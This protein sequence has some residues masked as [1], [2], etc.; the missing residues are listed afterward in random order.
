MT[1]EGP[2]GSSLEDVAKTCETNWSTE[3]TS[4]TGQNHSEYGHSHSVNADDPSRSTFVPK[5]PTFSDRLGQETAS[6]ISGPSSTGPENNNQQYEGT[7]TERGELEKVLRRALEGS[8]KKRFISNDNFDRIITQNSI[9]KELIRLRVGQKSHRQGLS[10]VITLSRR[11][12]FA[13]LCLVEKV[14]TVHD[15]I[16]EGL[17]DNDLPFVFHSEAE[18]RSREGKIIELFQNGQWKPSEKDNFETYQWYM[19]MPYLRLNCE[20]DPSVSQYIFEE[21]LVLPFAVLETYKEGGF[22][23]VRKVTFHS[24]HFNSEDFNGGGKCFFAIKSLYLPYDPH[25]RHDPPNQEV[26]ALIRMNETKHPHLVRLLATY[27]YEGGLNLIFPWADGNLQNFWKK[28]SWNNHKTPRDRTL[29]EW[30]AEQCLG[31]A[32]GLK[33][34]HDSS[35]E[36]SETRAQA[37]NNKSA[38]KNYG[39]HGDLKPENILWFRERGSRSGSNEFGILRI[40]D[41]GLA[42]FHGT[43]SK[44]SVPSENLG[45]TPTYRAPEFDIK[46]KVAPSYDIWC[47]GCVLLEFVE[48]YLRGWEGVDLFSK[49]RSV[50]CLTDIPGFTED[51]FFKHLQKL[52]KAIVKESVLDEIYELQTHERGSDFT[53]DMLDLIQHDLLRMR[54]E[55]RVSCD[56]IVKKTETILKN[57]QENP[58]Y[59]IDITKPI[60]EKQKT[61]FSVLIQH[62]SPK[63]TSQPGAEKRQSAQSSIASTKETEQ[64]T[65]GLGII[66]NNRTSPVDAIYET[67][68]GDES[69]PPS[70]NSEATP[71][72][73]SPAIQEAEAHLEVGEEDHL[74]A[75]SLGVIRDWPLTTNS[76]TTSNNLQSTPP[77]TTDVA[78]NNTILPQQLEAED[79]R[80]AYSANAESQTGGTTDSIPPRHEPGLQPPKNTAP[81]SARSEKSDDPSHAKMKSEGA[82]ERPVSWWGLR[83]ARTKC[84]FACS[85]PCFHRGSS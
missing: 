25:N 21:G 38:Q 31:L 76:S 9:F 63:M 48:W 44:D 22:S 84:F 7:V 55:I 49:K 30:I 82:E 26:E 1:E 40:A 70:K 62:M 65:P 27:E 85:I 83:W 69:N 16:D 74:G 75:P 12:I 81:R 20:R 10:K 29:A 71:P 67:E 59:C 57:C 68:A 28:A 61:N 14:N 24:A 23:M 79:D 3:P 4:D 64:S 6:S 11:K 78:E 60:P 42:D 52:Q 51:S 19:L 35:P 36:E 37:P 33:T 15:F 32:Q 43:K 5:Q 18:I 66:N 54:P 39:R 34:I 77:E 72:Q 53:L 13:I 17:R 50:D 45:M 58:K 2:Q 46:K 80:A 41:F 73:T 47:F 8:K 56:T